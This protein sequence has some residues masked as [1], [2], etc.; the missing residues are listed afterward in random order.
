[1]PRSP[2]VLFILIT[3]MI[4][5]MGIGLI[6]PVMPDLLRQVGGGDLAH[7]AIWGGILATGF[8]VMQFLFGP[9]LGNLSDRFGRRPVLLIALT[10]MALDYLVMAMAGAIWLLLIGRMVGGITAATHS[11]ATAFMADISDPKDKAAN[12]G[13]ISAAFGFGFIIGPLLGGLLGELGSRAPFYAAAGLAAGN[14]VLG[15]FV[16]PETV[17]DRIRRPFD[18]R[19][20]NPL[21]AFRHLSHLPGIGRLLT[22][23]FLYQVSVAVFPAV[24][25]YFTRARFGWEEGMTGLSLAAY[26]A[27]MVVVQGFL[28]RPVLARLGEARTILVGLSLS[29]AALAGIAF[30]PNGWAVLALTPINALGAMVL[31][32]VQGMMSRIV[33]DD[34]QGELQGVLTSA[35]AVAMILSPLL[36]TQ[37][38]A[39]FTG[40]GAPVYLPGA[41]FLVALLLMALGTVIFAG[42]SARAPA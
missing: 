31:P 5:S 6:L 12:F 24:W 25:A 18:W 34:G 36:M 22:L 14:A 21:G 3:V 29:M 2:A 35:A 26:G 17:T 42:R 15:W 20:A 7:A 40:P 13:L 30:V 28:I 32:A 27:S 41:P 1:M 23:Y 9:T 37:T 10:V 4:D 19:R 11:T 16:L 8:A 33:P 39:A 38:F